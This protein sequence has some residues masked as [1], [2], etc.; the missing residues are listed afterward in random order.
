M[1]QK[2]GGGGV[3]ERGAY[4]KKISE[5]GGGGVGCRERGLNR[6]FTVIRNPDV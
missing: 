1:S 4:Y 5:L 6:A 2:E 3:L